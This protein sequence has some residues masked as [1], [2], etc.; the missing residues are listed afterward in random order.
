MSETQ[1]SPAETNGV[2]APATPEQRGIVAR[3]AG[4]T[5]FFIIAPI[6]GLAVAAVVMTGVAVY[7]VIKITIVPV[8]RSS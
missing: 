7:D 5:R 4:F 1:N 2:A 3:V 6:T 8:L